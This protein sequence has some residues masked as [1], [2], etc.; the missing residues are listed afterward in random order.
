MFNVFEAE[1]LQ[2]DLDRN[3]AAALRSQVSQEVPRDTPEAD[4]ATSLK[5]K[6]L[7]CEVVQ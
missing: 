2:H 6:P 5:L 3:S 7:Q 4:A 1:F